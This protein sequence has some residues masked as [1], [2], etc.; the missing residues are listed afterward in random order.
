MTSSLKIRFG[1]KRTM[2]LLTVLIMIVS[3]LP[4]WSTPVRAA[5]KEPSIAKKATVSLN[6][7]KALKITKNGYTISAVTVQSSKTAVA[8]ATATKSKITVYGVKAGKAKITATVS[9]KK[10]DAV[11]TFKLTSTVTVEDPSPELD[12]NKIEVGETTIVSVPNAAKGAKITYSSSDK[13]VLTVSKKG[14]VTAVGE[15]KATITAKVVLQKT[16]YAKKVTKK[17]KVGKVVVKEAPVDGLYSYERATVNTQAELDAALKDSDIRR[18]T[19]GEEAR[20]L[21]IPEGYYTSIDLIVDAPFASIVNNGTFKTVTIKAIA[22]NT[23][24]EKAYGNRITVDNTKPVHII[25]DTAQELTSLIFTGITTSPSKVQIKSGTVSN[26][27]VIGAQAV[28]IPVEG[29]SKVENIRIS[30]DATITLNTTDT[31]VVTNLQ[32]SGAGA[33]VFVTADGS[34]VIGSISSEADSSYTSVVTNGS[35]TV[36]EVNVKG[37]A[38]VAIDGTSSNTTKVVVKDA[39]GSNQV[40]VNTSSVKIETDSNTDADKVV[41]N[42]TGQALTTSTKNTD[43]STTTGV[44]VSDGTGTTGG[45]TSSGGSSSGGSSN[46]NL[47]YLDYLT[48]NKD[49]AKVG[50]RITATAYVNNSASASSDITY[51]WTR[52]KDGR[53]VTVGSGRTYTIKSNDIGADLEVEATGGDHTITGYAWTTVSIVDYYTVAVG[54]GISNGNVFITSGYQSV[55][56]NSSTVK[57]AAAGDT[58][59]VSLS[60]SSGYSFSSV[61]I[62]KAGGGTVTPTIASNYR[63]ATFTMPA[64]NVTVTATYVQ[65]GTAVTASNI[66]TTTPQTINLNTG[67]TSGNTVS[68]APT[69]VSGVTFSYAETTD[70]GN[71]FTIATSGSNVGRVTFATGKAAGSYSG[72]FTITATGNGTTRT[73]TATKV[74][75][76]NV[77]VSAPSAARSAA[78]GNVTVSGTRYADIDETDLTLTLS[79]EVFV[80]LAANTDVSSWFTNKP[81]GLTAKIKTIVA[82]NATTAAVT[83]SGTPTATLNAAMAITIPAS[84]VSGSAITVATNSNAKYQITA[85]P[86]VDLQHSINVADTTATMTENVTI[87]SGN[88]LNIPEGKTLSTGSFSITNNGTVLINGTL[89]VASGKSLTNNGTVTVAAGGVLTNNGTLS[90][91][92]S[93]TLTNNGTVTNSAGATITIAGTITNNGTLTNSGTLTNNGVITNPSSGTLTN[94]GTF[95]S[96]G[97]ITGRG[98]YSGGIILDAAYLGQQASA[99]HNDDISTALQKYKDQSWSVV[100]G[101]NDQRVFYA[102]YSQ[103]SEDYVLIE[104]CTTVGGSTYRWVEFTNGTGSFFHKLAENINYFESFDTSVETDA[105]GF[106]SLAEANSLKTAMNNAVV[107]T[108]GFNLTINLYVGSVALDKDNYE[109]A[110]TLVST[111]T[112]HCVD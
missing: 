48:L 66:S 75:T 29:N 59:T 33:E 100:E 82:A 11:K 76:V 2:A 105:A 77:T 88:T 112:F 30:G 36:S 90:I 20:D 14:V 83:I 57:K 101:Q 56:E 103:T 46:A 68:I 49:E 53:T 80:S 89:T 93:K 104:C 60:A 65:N 107:T 40:T 5:E 110:G 102:F 73:G 7:T 96:E 50:D 63:T 99:D 79:N 95:N 6:G 109:D 70:P 4:I 9:A 69:G 31:A 38:S 37:R 1:F 32:V 62:T 28:E 58:V 25:I 47:K 45:G 61:T 92:T 67:Y 111:R 22:E 97:D 81:A 94:S 71:C 23:W 98:T 34:S 24:R 44:T 16:K 72:T 87:L 52:T 21:T 43:G 8:Q 17:I 91:A 3:V 84:G 18:I 15:G 108:T 26:L 54:T 51:K 106:A 86:L 12:D 10:G 19:I 74:I 41:N 35:S 85:D 13:S 55:T 27:N 64:S 39:T 78:V 42:R